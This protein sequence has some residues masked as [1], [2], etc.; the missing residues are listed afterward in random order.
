MRCSITA[1]EIELEFGVMLR[2]LS[3]LSALDSFRLSVSGIYQ[4]V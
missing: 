4:K 3:V 1:V 2:Y